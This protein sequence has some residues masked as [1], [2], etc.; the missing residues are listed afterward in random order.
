MKELSLEIKPKEGYGELNFGETTE[1]VIAF[2]GDAEEVEDIADDEE[3]N[4]VILNY[5]EKGI[6]IFMEGVEKS[7]VA[8]FET[9]NPNSSM[10]GK[11]LFEMK[12]KAITDLMGTKG[13]E[14]AETEMEEEDIKRVSYDDAMIDFFFEDDELVAVNWGVLVNEKGEIEEMPS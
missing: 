14:I 4:T 3:F 9:D 12:E 10:Y 13:F 7:V 2:L 11:K 1:E 5:W 8:C 6:S